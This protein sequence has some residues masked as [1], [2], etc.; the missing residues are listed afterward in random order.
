MTCGEPRNY[1][2]ERRD[3]RSMNWRKSAVAATHQIKSD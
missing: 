1:V 2:R 3:A